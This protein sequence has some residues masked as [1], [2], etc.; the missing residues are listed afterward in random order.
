MQ[1]M[2][3]N[4]NSEWL[5]L[6]CPLITHNILFFDSS[7]SDSVSTYI[8]FPVYWYFH[9]CK[10]S[11]SSPY[12]V[13]CLLFSGVQIENISESAAAEHARHVK[14][15]FSPYDTVENLSKQLEDRERAEEEEAY[16]R[17]CDEKKCASIGD[18]GGFSG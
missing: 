10:L 15:T 9:I 6:L 4:R 11:Q 17:E 3:S 1:A 18:W 14:A 8:D 2:N 7:I 13:H 16:R 5:K 12:C